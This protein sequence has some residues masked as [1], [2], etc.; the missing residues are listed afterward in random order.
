MVTSLQSNL[1]VKRFLLVECDFAMPILHLSARA[2]IAS[3]DT[4]LPKQLIYAH[5]FQKT[6]VRNSCKH[7]EFSKA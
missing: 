7:T 3:F 4:R 1:L 6:A 5:V 2:H